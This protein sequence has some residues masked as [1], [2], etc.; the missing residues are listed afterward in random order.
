MIWEERFELMK[1]KVREE[2]PELKIVD[3]NFDPFQF[4]ANCPNGNLMNC[5]WEITGKLAC[6]IFDA[7]LNVLEN[8]STHKATLISDFE[9]LKD[10][11]D[12]FFGKYC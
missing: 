6:S 3:N 4:T 5:G 12:R 8:T 2:I 9:F 1:D 11:P 7:N 10:M